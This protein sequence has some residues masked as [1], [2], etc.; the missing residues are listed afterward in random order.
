MNC[1]IHK[2]A[3]LLE[4]ISLKGLTL[5][6]P[7]VIGGVRLVPLLRDV[8]QEDLR[9]T[10]RQYDEDITMVQIDNKSMYYSYIPHSLVAD[11]TNN[12]S[13]A[14]TFGTQ[15]ESNK[16][17]KTKDGKSYNSGI[18]T[19]RIMSKMRSREN[20]NRLRFLPMDMSMEGFLALHFGGPVIAWEEYSR[21]AIKTGLSPRVETTIPGRL[22]TGLQDALRVF[23]IH[24]TQVGSLVFVG[25]ALAS[26]FVVPHPEDYRY[27][28]ETLLTDSYG[29]LIYY[30]GLHAQE[31]NYHPASIDPDNIN[32]LA[33]MRNEIMRVRTDWAELH[34]IMT[35]NLL[36]CPIQSEMV[37]KMGPF[38]M[39]RFMT[40]MNP[41][42]ENHIG[43]VILR[44][45]GTLEY[46][47][48]FRLSA[49]QCRRAYLLMQLSNNNWDL[50]KCAEKLACTKNQL[51]YRLEKAGFGYLLHQH[52]LDA[53]QSERRKKT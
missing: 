42:S 33:E 29:E 27:L 35:S 10:R 48:S 39:Q 51:V 40:S 4:S 12:G 6:P 9:L 36:G 13:P 14:A 11:W 18:M 41:K 46:M 16:Q 53:A 17:K 3:K 23:E 30:Y 50:E 43:E 21:S 45:D 37:Y 19:A 31:N 52:V 22:I 49:S 28:H 2:K 32:S 44:T 20:K 1:N 38:Q 8:V 47:K 25:D 7:Q 5:A 34:T 24:P 26:V 15:I